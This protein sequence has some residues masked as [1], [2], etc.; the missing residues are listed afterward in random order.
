MLIVKIQVNQVHQKFDKKADSI[1]IS[2]LQ[3]N[4]K[5]ITANMNNKHFHKDFQHITSTLLKH[6]FRKI[7]AKNIQ[8]IS[9]KLINP[10]LISNHQEPH[11]RIINFRIKIKQK[12]FLSKRNKNYKKYAGNKLIIIIST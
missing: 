4:I 5:D 9:I 1:I 8:N 2:T 11:I 3:K 10:P 7:T 12:E 6:L